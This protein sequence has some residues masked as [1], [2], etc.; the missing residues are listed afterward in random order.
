M[1]HCEK[2][3]LEMN[4]LFRK[5]NQMNREH[6]S[7]ARNYDKYEIKKWDNISKSQFLTAISFPKRIRDKHC[8]DSSIDYTPASKPTPIMN[9]RLPKR[10][11]VLAMPKRRKNVATVDMQ[12]AKSEKKKFRDFPRT[13]TLALKRPAI[14]T[15]HARCMEPENRGPIYFKLSKTYDPIKRQ[16]WIEKNSAPKQVVNRLLQVDK[17]P[18]KLLTR[19]QMK[20][21]IDRLA[22]K[23]PK[24]E[25]TIN[26]VITPIVSTEYLDQ[27]EQEISH[28]IQSQV[29]TIKSIPEN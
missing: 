6:R 24:K 3:K 15:V 17:N 14:R 12:K 7:K 26:I 20:D 9:F 4:Q 1:N 10:L 19:Q 27:E 21:M 25:T 22:Y 11:E 2:I 23:K 16:Q 13:K 8:A 18:P 29:T 28:T 5:C